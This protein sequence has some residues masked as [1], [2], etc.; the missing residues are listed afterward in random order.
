MEQSGL[1]SLASS[2]AAQGRYGD[3]TLVHMAPEEVHGLNALA[4]AHGAG[5][6]TINPQTG[7]PE[8]FSLKKIFKSALPMILGAVL[9]PLTG[10]LINPFTASAL[11]GGGTA[12]ATGSLKKGLM[13]GLSAYGGASLA[14]AT[15][16]TKMVPSMM[17]N[18]AGA[19]GAAGAGAGPAVTEG[20]KALSPTFVNTP[21]SLAGAAQFG[22]AAMSPITAA[23]AIPQ[24]S[25]HLASAAAQT[26]ANPALINSPQA[27][28][29]AMAGASPANTGLMG[30]AQG[31]GGKFAD[32]A[33]INGVPRTLTTG[34]AAQGA[35]SGLSGIAAGFRPGSSNKAP[36]E[37]KTI[38][39]GPYTPTPRTV[40]FPQ[41]G[42]R[43]PTDSSEYQYFDKV[44]PMPGYIEID[45][46]AASG[47]GGGG[48]GAL[49]TITKAGLEEL[50]KD[51]IFAAKGGEL[52][53]GS[54]IMDA[55]SVAE[56]GN[57]SSS[58]GQEVL[59]KLGGKPIKGKGDGVS[60]SVEA[61]ID[62]KRPARLA[63]D[64]V[65]FSPEAV[66]R[67]G[68]GNHKRGTQK[69]YQLV[70]NAEKARKTVGRG[71]DS[72]LRSAMRV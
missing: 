36:K 52:Q 17:G 58:A 50:L 4:H 11:V 69:L 9:T 12:L 39:N 21:A 41:P 60:D 20:L 53:T 2:M 23:A 19:A 31:F 15:G 26:A 25:L 32:A 10:G 71:Q 28:A 51:K 29:S 68:Q 7:L 63:R 42:E 16:L 34:L 5:G 33:A 57:G 66:K 61:K 56:L 22:G 46:R 1:H 8:A 44:N 27:L 18:T 64:E 72:G 45:K 59:A 48:G 30:M 24:Q 14:G 62:G 43:S 67:L 37:E 40:R 13:A 3:S 65:H 49:S 47:G 6:L 54:F 35:I 55:R 70:A 38:Y